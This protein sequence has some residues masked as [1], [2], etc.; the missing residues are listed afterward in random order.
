M[1]GKVLYSDTDSVYCVLDKNVN[2]DGFLFDSTL[3]IK[4]EVK[5]TKDVKEWVCIGSKAY[6][7]TDAVKYVSTGK[8]ITIEK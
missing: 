2:V 4:N 3:G 5:I 6:S 8:G 1:S 7:Y